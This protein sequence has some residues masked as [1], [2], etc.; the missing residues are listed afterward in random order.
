MIDSSAVQL[1]VIGYSLAGLL[2][3]VLNILQI[4]FWRKRLNA[5][6]LF[7]FLFIS[8]IWAF[9]SAFNLYSNITS[10]IYLVTLEVFRNFLSFLFLIQLNRSINLTSGSSLFHSISRVAYGSIFFMVGLLFFI[11]ISKE[12]NS[13]IGFDLR[14]L[15][16]IT[17]AVSG[18]VIVEHIFRQS[19]DEARWALKFLCFAFFIM[20]AYDFYLY[21][22]AMLFKTLDANIIQA[23]GFVYA[24]AIPLLALA[25]SRS[26]KIGGNVS[27][28][29]A[30]VFY[31]SAII[32]TAA[33]LIIMSIGGFYLRSFG[34]DWSKVL[35]IT[36]MFTGAL[37]LFVIMFSG[38]FRARFRVFI[39]KYFLEYKFDYREQWLGLIRELSVDDANIKLDQRALHAMMEI[40]DCP[41][42]MLWVRRNQQVYA[43]LANYGM[44]ELLHETESTDSSLANFLETWQWVINLDQHNQDPGMYDGL[45]LPLWLKQTHSVWLIVPLML[46]SRLYGFVVLSHPRASREFNWEDIDLLKTVGRQVAIHLAQ[47]R[48]SLALVQARQFEAFNRFSA[49]VVHDLKNLVSQLALVVKNSEKHKHNPAFMDDAISTV[50]NAVERMNKLLAQLRSGAIE[51]TMSDKIDLNRAIKSAIKEKSNGL[52]VPNLDVIDQDLLV[53]GDEAR[54]ASILGH[55]IQNAQDATADNGLIQVKMSQDKNTA[56]IEIRDSGSGMDENFIKNRLFKPFDTT[57]GLTGMGIGAHESRSFIEELGGN[58]IVDSQVGKGSVFTIQ[59]PLL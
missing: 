13:F 18:L 39:D 48:S 32:A 52:P 49:Y 35:A 16:H 46:Q 25:I 23:R 43:P 56:V 44:D 51:N 1:G 14:I 6:I 34:G 15:G 3:F 26:N 42:G 59:L 21:S 2:F 31:T 40:M 5:P 53:A 55:I 36:F 17:I 33:Y 57:K 24:I 10:S 22:D 27:A 58:L 45:E 12:V 4:S 8:V 38:A 20:F 29:R 37:L 9:F 7:A 28:S 41:A 30:T 19:K 11:A 47:E 50:D 54:L